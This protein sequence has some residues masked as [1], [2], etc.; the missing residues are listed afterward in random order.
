MCLKVLLYSKFFEIFQIDKVDKKN[1]LLEITRILTEGIVG[2]K[3]ADFV[4]KSVKV[5]E[6]I[7]K[8]IFQKHG[9]K[10]KK[11]NTPDHYQTQTQTYRSPVSDL[12]KEFS[13]ESVESSADVENK[14][15][16]ESWQ[17][18]HK[19]MQNIRSKMKDKKGWPNFSNVF[20]ISALNNDGVLDLK[21]R[22]F[23][24]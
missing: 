8:E 21:V 23:F 9:L 5:N 19:R 20:M 12:V 10:L 13:V 18:Y 2:N 1:Y 22:L 6:K 7:Q 15:G 17:D 11:S 16:A 4:R 3:K 24:S 14:V